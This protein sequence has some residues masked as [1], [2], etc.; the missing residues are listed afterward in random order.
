MPSPSSFLRRQ[1]E[2]VS[3]TTERSLWKLKR[4]NKNAGIMEDWK[5]GIVG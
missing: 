3:F 1:E 4:E 2:Y 5:I